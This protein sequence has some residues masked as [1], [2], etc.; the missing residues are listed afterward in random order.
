MIA[1]VSDDHRDCIGNLK[2]RESWHKVKGEMIGRAIKNESEKRDWNLKT[3][4]N[5]INLILYYRNSYCFFVTEHREA[6]ELL[7]KFIM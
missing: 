4:P 1:N 2:E 6:S 5:I 3:F 7:P